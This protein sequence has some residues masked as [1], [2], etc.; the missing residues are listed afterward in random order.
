MYFKVIFHE[1]F[2]N[3]NRLCIFSKISEKAH[4]TQRVNVSDDN[5]KFRFTCTQVLSNLNIEKF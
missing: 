5:L 4:G 3:E 2:Q 1:I